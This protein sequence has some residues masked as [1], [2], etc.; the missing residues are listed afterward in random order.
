MRLSDVQGKCRH[1]PTVYVNDL[2][3][4]SSQELL[5]RGQTILLAVS[6]HATGGRLRLDACGGPNSVSIAIPYGSNSFL[7]SFSFAAW[8]ITSSPLILG[9][10]L[11]D[12]SAHARA[13][14]AGIANTRIIEINQIWAAHAG[15]AVQTSVQRFEAPVFHGAGSTGPGQN[16]SFPVSQV[17]AKPLLANNTQWAVL[18]VNIWNQTCDLVVSMSEIHPVLAAAK[19]MDVERIWEST[20]SGTWHEGVFRAPQVAPHDSTFIVLTTRHLFTN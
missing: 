7:S 1:R 17:W 5:R 4:T 2:E 14:A 8:A 13:L 12:P 6:R 10:D 18:M 11:T 9:Y 16:V 3:P 20:A 19:A 15:K